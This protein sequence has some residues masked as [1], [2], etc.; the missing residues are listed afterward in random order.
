[1]QQ[2]NLFLFLLFTFLIFTT[3]QFVEA[4]LFPQAR[5][6]RQPPV[7]AKIERPLRAEPMLWTELS[8]AMRAPGV[9]GVGDVLALATPVGL[10]EFQASNWRAAVLVMAREKAT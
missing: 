3:W 5:R 1:M 6:K 2:K 8:T 9:P 4:W 10:A 7:A